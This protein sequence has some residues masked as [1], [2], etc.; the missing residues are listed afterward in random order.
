M[1]GLLANAISQINTLKSRLTVAR[2]TKLDNLDALIS[3]RASA[4]DYTPSRA[5]KLDEMDVAISS[6]A[7]AAD[8]TSARA[9]K[10]D[11]LDEAISSRAA[12]A[13][14]NATR[15]GYLDHLQYQPTAIKSIQRGTILFPE[16]SSN[17]T[18]SVTLSP[19]VNPANT[20]L[21]MLGFMTNQA[22]SP[23]PSYMYTMIKLT[24]GGTK[25]T[26]YTADSSSLAY[27]EV[28][29]ELTEYY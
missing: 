28:S 4:T 29:W 27:V 3:S 26:G 13:D 5:A 1:I 2:A 11:E 10:L 14:Y 9:A 21:R 12:A 20:E 7:A 18:V 8:Y 23:N 22:S 16:G 24:D 6:R 19:A 25:V 15:A 17:D